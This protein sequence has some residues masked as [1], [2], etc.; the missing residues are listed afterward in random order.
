MVLDDGGRRGVGGG[1]KLGVNDW[2]GVCDEGGVMKEGFISIN[3]RERG[4][5]YRLVMSVDEIER[6][7]WRVKA[8]GDGR[9][10][11]DQAVGS[12]VGALVAEERGG[13]LMAAT[14]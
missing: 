7:G 10:G 2:A 3:W 11:S 9:A 1:F 12:G 13:S 8:L 5:R 6:H 4:W 14:K